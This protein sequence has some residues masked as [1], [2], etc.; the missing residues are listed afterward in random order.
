MLGFKLKIP[1]GAMV[2]SMLFVIAFKLLSGKGWSAPKEYQL[3]VQILLG[4]M[5]G[6]TFEKHMLENIINLAIPIVVSTLALV[7]T[8][9]LL[10]IAFTKLGLIDVATCYLGTNPGA[11]S[12]LAFIAAENGADP[13]VVMTF[14]FVR[15]VFVVITAPW[16]VSMIASW[17]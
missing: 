14:H 16:I 6:S 11:I 8:G 5:I 3:I 17:R 12:V 2:G 13:T 9:L 7:G 4:I 1:S 10:C 15:V